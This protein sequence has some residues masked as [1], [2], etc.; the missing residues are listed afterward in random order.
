MKVLYVYNFAYADYQSDSIYHGLIDSGVE[1]YET[2]YPAYMLQGY[3]NAHYLHGKGFTI[4]GKLN[5]T[6]RVDE[7]EVIK[8]KIKN[9]F[10]DLV[11]YGCVYTHFMLPQRQSLDYL[12]E[13]IQ[14]YSKD[15]VHFVDGCDDIPNFAYGL[16]LHKYG[17]VWKTNGADDK[18]GKSIS[19]AIPE[20]QL[21]EYKPQKEKFFADII[22]GVQETYRFTDEN[23]YYHDYAISYY[24]KTW[25]KGQWNCMRHLEILANRCIPYFP[26]LENCP[27][28]IM[29][30][31]PKEIILETNKYAEQGK[32]HPQYEELNEILFEYTKQNLT[33]KK[34]AERFLNSSKEINEYSL[35]SIQNISPLNP[36]ISKKGNSNHQYAEI[37]ERAFQKA[38]LDKQDVPDWI[39]YYGGAS[40]T[41]YR[42]MINDIIKN[43]PDARYL[44]IGMWTGSTLFAA[45]SNNKVK[46]TGI[47]NWTQGFYGD[48]K[49]QFYQ[50]LQ[51]CITYDNSI[52]LYETEFQKIDYTQIGKHNVFLYDGPH[53]EQ[54]QY[55]GV[56]LPYDALDDTFILVVDDW[57][58]PSPR[59][60]TFRALNDK[61]IE[62]VYS[63]E[64]RTTSNDYFP[65]E[66]YHG[67]SH[68]WHDGYLIAV[69]QKR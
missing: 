59:N 27:E 54:E 36:Y 16:G 14:S 22:P 2:A 20:S 55:D 44:E 49:N 28:W 39:L 63:I 60:G 18:H 30:N 42:I 13:V 10:Y 65:P 57:N 35:P 5:H 8:E 31:F 23:E 48:V 50:F 67:Q 12:Q 37:I 69:C 15:K 53:D 38:C 41:R 17:T 9:R 4:H 56:S 32:I 19:F 40:G 51:G 61:N 46:A 26:G 43:I 1:V 62:I 21:L 33:T 68:H 58:W 6:P 3:E 66:E 25:R 34:L 29:K 45:L 24:G 11:I 52:A 64:I 47:D 7:P